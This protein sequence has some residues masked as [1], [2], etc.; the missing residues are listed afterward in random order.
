MDNER[1][2]IRREIYDKP[3]ETTQ[4]QS[5]GVESTEIN[6]ELLKM[7]PPER[8]EKIKEKELRKYKAAQDKKWRKYLESVSE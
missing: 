2:R 1:E 5:D 4:K 7:F 3:K 8:L 6:P